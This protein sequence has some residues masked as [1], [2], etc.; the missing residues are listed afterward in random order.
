MIATPLAYADTT[1]D[2]NRKVADAQAKIA[3]LQNQLN[4]AQA[5][6]DSWINSSNDQAVL[7]N[8][9]QTA[10]TEAQEALDI[11]SS[12]YLSKKNDYD[13]WYTEVQQAEQLVSAA[14][15]DVN[16]AADVVDNTYNDYLVAQ[17]NADNAE[18]EM[19]IAQ[20]NY[21]TQ[22]INIGGQ[23]SQPGLVVDIY[24]GIN[25]NGN[26]PS[27][28]DIVYTKCKTVTVSN[29]NANWGSGSILVVVAITLCLTIVDILHTQQQQ[30]FIFKHLLTMVLY[31]D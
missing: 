26:P 3:D 16:A 20:N 7:I 29:I 23:G 19:N 13:S 1:D 2:Y 11:A 31:E 30:K 12:D 4:A 9:A 15:T 28:S 18:A 5:N 25:K 24:V 22:L 27:R 8:S 17:A 6:L 14:I 21:D 10:A